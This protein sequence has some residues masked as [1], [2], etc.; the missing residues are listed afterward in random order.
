MA[1]TTNPLD[2]DEDDIHDERT[3]KAEKSVAAILAQWDERDAADEGWDDGKP[4][5]VKKAEASVAALLRGEATPATKAVKLRPTADLLTAVEVQIESIQEDIDEADDE[6]VDELQGQ[7][8]KLETRRTR[9][10]ERLDTEAEEAE[11]AA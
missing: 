11:E 4:D 6:Q 7:L 9:L 2:F 10:E 3:T 1:D 5:N 8:D